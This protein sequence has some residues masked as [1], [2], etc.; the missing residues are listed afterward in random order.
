M[1]LKSILKFRYQTCTIT[2]RGLHFCYHGVLCGCMGAAYLLK[3]EDGPMSNGSPNA[4]SNLWCHTA[5][6][7]YVVST[8]KCLPTKFT[9]LMPEK[10][11]LHCLRNSISEYNWRRR[12][13]ILMGLIKFAEYL[14]FLLTYI[15]WVL[16]ITLSNS[17]HTRLVS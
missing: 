12:I 14:F 11:S 6:V 2:T 4:L 16:L 1:V 8:V 5:N 7:L 9:K 3:Q 10:V 13:A 15:L 17:L